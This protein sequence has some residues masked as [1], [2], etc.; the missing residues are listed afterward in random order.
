MPVDKGF[1]G[2]AFYRALEAVVKS[3]SKNWKGVSA[4]TGIGASTLTRMAQGR[5]P[6]A[7]SLAVLSAWADLNPSDFV[8]APYKKAPS[9]SIGRISTL[10]RTDPSLDADA[11]EAI[12]SIVGAAYRQMR[13]EEK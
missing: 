2:D 9:N 6:D 8:Q 4:E 5:K 10:L 1:D 11:A 3:R 12:D 13:T 7:A